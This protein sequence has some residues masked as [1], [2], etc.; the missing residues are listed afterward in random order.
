MK[1]TDLPTDLPKPED[2]GLCNHLLNTSI[3][4]ISLPTQDGI[5]L[6]LNRQ[7]TFR[8]VIYFFSMT[9]HPNKQLPEKWDLVPGASGCTVE[10][11]SFRDHYDD[12]IKNNALP[13]GISTQS[14]TDLKEMTN[15]LVIPYD[16]IS[17]Q[18]LI[19]TNLI[20]LPTFSIQNKKYIKRLTLI[21]EK[22]IIK[23]VFY[24]IFP[25][26]NHIDEVLDW[27]NTN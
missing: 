17:D 23:K 10:N 20:K 22:S 11:C 7:D 14:V 15:R 12:L 2:D 6:Q 16:I 24:P 9:G 8:L 13:I 18:E 3:P 5:P 1:L 19:L 4:D 26:H 25:P 21:V 27:L